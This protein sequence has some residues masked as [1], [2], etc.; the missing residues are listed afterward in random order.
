[1][2]IKRTE[3][4]TAISNQIRELR[5]MKQRGEITSSAKQRETD[6]LWIVANRN[7]ITEEVRAL[8]DK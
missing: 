2:K 5:R 1:M 4:P 3:T 7:M 6:R 8:L